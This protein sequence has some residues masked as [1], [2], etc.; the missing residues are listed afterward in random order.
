MYSTAPWQLAVE[1]PFDAPP[2][3]LSTGAL[4]RPGAGSIVTGCAAE[5]PGVPTVQF[6]EYAFGTETPDGGPT[7][8]PAVTS[9]AVPPAATV[10]S[11]VVRVHG[12]A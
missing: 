8:P 4:D 10:A 5:V 2:F 9:S 12:S 1:H 11:A 6:P 3:P 7:A